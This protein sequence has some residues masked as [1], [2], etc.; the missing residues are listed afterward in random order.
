M[1]GFPTEPLSKQEPRQ[2]EAE[3]EAASLAPEPRSSSPWHDSPGWQH[4]VIIGLPVLSHS[5]D[6]LPRLGSG[7]QGGERKSSRTHQVAQ[8]VPAALWLCG[9]HATLLSRLTLSHLEIKAPPEGHKLY[10]KVKAP[11]ESPWVC[12]NLPHGSGTQPPDSCFPAG[13]NNCHH[14]QTQ[15]QG[16]EQYHL[17]I[18][19]QMRGRARADMR[20]L[21]S[22]AG[23]IPPTPTKSSS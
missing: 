23:P 12:A 22:K 1:T 4:C 18:S 19:I 3:P 9:T 11:K 7:E 14:S 13:T 20:A 21:R 2:P 15:A 8:E 17:L 5:C 10:H 16:R 6:L